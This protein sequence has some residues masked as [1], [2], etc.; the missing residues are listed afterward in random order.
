[1][2]KLKNDH[3]GSCINSM[4]ERGEETDGN[5]TVQW[6][7]GDIIVARARII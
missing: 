2:I 7:C 5:Q 3:F 4:E 6:S 1:M